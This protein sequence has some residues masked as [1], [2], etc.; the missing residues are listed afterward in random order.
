MIYYATNAQFHTHLEKSSTFRANGCLSLANA[1]TYCDRWPNQLIKYLMSGVQWW[2][3]GS[4]PSGRSIYHRLHDIHFSLDCKLGLIPIWCG[5]C[6]CAVACKTIAYILKTC[7]HIPWIFRHTLGQHHASW[8]LNSWRLKVISR[9]HV[10]GLLLSLWVNFSQQHR[11]TVSNLNTF[12][13]SKNLFSIWKDKSN[14]CKSQLLRTSKP[15]GWIYMVFT[16]FNL[17]YSRTTHWYV[18]TLYTWKVIY[19]WPIFI[20]S[21][22]RGATQ[23]IG[24]VK[25]SQW[26]NPYSLPLEGVLEYISVAP[27]WCGVSC[28]PISW[29]WLYDSLSFEW[30]YSRSGTPFWLKC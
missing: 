25:L 22:Y 15:I 27:C 17:Y 29:R 28:T 3:L 1:I 10:I 2:P 26:G 18:C 7:S 13:C 24:L 19:L 12:W 20:H 21:F 16:A 4:F 11:G 5:S 23:W 6:K 9:Y 8:Y 14:L 30:E